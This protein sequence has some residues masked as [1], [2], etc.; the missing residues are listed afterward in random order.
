[1]IGRKE[2][3]LQ[4]IVIATA[5]NVSLGDVFKD[6]DIVLTE[7]ECKELARETIYSYRAL[8]AIFHK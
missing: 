1:M 3:A 7:E 2:Q 6:T 5:S 4:L 8:H